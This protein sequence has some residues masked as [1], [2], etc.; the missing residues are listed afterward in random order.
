MREDDHDSAMRPRRPWAAVGAVLVLVVVG[1]LLARPSGPAPP[2]P[3]SD[4]PVHRHT[5]AP[6]RGASGVEQPGMVAVV[7]ALNTA[8]LEARVAPLEIPLGGR[9]LRSAVTT[10]GLQ[11]LALGLETVGG[12]EATLQVHDAATLRLVADLGTQPGPLEHLAVSPEAESV[13]WY[14]PA[15]R[16][17]G[18]RV[19]RLAFAEIWAGRALDPQPAQRRSV[20]LPAGLDVLGIEPLG[21]GHVGVA[22]VDAAS[23]SLRV[24][25]LDLTGDDTAPLTD[26]TL[27]GL[28]GATTPPLIWHTSW[29]LLHIPHV[30][31]DGLTTV[32]LHSGAHH[33]SEP[34]DVPRRSTGIVEREAALLPEL[35][36]VLVTG[37]LR[38]AGG[39]AGIDRVTPLGTAA[40]VV[41]SGPPELRWRARAAGDVLLG[42]G[43]QRAVLT[44]GP[45]LDTLRAPP[46]RV[47]TVDPE[48][49]LRPA[50]AEIEL[51]GTLLD[52]RP[53]PSR[54]RLTAV[55]AHGG[56]TV[57]SR[58]G[59]E[60]GAAPLVER[61]FSAEAIVH[62]SAIVVIEQR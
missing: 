17:A 50:G 2:V 58:H 54:P 40:F 27:P 36:T 52:L 61:R 3:T 31:D 35:A 5:D 28:L 12:G 44:S 30:N 1:A 22:A 15:S 37:R 13:V 9:R 60:D 48:V 42:V 45:S 53:D 46:V 38:R 16:S 4:L 33:R 29:S 25:V 24:L 47:V 62:L 57:V 56:A 34:P 41:S 19:H 43:A 10:R 18:A 51:T 49:G 26:V 6:P 32:E 11:R 7:H 21:G 59:W 8:S 20:A 55:R 14:T 39:S 23:G